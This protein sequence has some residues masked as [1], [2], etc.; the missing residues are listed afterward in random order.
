MS[1][2]KKSRRDFL[3]VTAVGTAALAVPVS[4][5]DPLERGRATVPAT[6]KLG[7]AS[8]SLRELSRADAIAGIRALRSKYVNIKSFHL[9]YE[10]SLKD[11]AAGRREFESAGLE[12]VGGGLVPLQKDDD[13]DVRMYFEYARA[14]GMSLMVI[15]PTPTTL[16][17]IERFVREYDIKVAIH[18]HG[19]EDPYFP[20]PRDALPMI[21]DMDPRVGLCVDLGHTARTGVDVVEA[22]HQAG[23]RLLDIHAKDL[24]DMLVRES[25]CIVGEGAMPIPAIFRQ[26][27]AMNYA[28]YVNLEYEIDPMDP[29]PGMQRSF[30]YMR[31]VLAGLGIQEG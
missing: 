31:G 10:S 24:K 19:P 5:R 26:L 4:L 2:Q 28:G 13:D 29:L 3:K 17:R 27:G 20:G 11:L 21:R 8:Y 22:L 16:P 23:D 15:G 1:D 18:N 12:I 14:A 25:Q 9:P 6:I 7:V 30:A